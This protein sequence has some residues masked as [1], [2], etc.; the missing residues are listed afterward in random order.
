[1]LSS[2]LYPPNANT[3]GENAILSSSDEIVPHPQKPS[4]YLLK[5]SSIAIKRLGRPLG[6]CL[7]SRAS[8]MGREIDC[9][10]KLTKQAFAKERGRHSK[11]LRLV[12]LLSKSSLFEQSET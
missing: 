7:S 5:Y 4:I 3:G 9:F 11:R 12:I 8:M 2:D 6:H 1:M 10:R